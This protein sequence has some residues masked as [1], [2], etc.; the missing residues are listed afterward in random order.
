MEFKNML[1]NVNFRHE[2][3]KKV[4]QTPEEAR[5]NQSI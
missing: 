1:N 3:Y 2:I 5:A 4:F